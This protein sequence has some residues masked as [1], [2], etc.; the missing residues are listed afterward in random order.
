M[1]GFLNGVTENAV[2]KSEFGCPWWDDWVT[3]RKCLKIGVPTGNIGPASY[4]GAWHDFPMPNGGTFNQ[5]EHV[6]EQ[7]RWF[8]HIRTHH[9]TPWV[10]FWI[11]RGGLQKATVSP[12]HGWMFFRVINGKLSLMML[13]RSADFPVGVPAD[14]VQYGAL[15]LMMSH[16]TG[17]T[18]HE[19]VHAFFDAHIYM[20]QF[21]SVETMIHRSPKKLP[22]LILT[23]E[24]LGIE[25]I[26]DFRP[27][28]F[29]LFDYHPHPSIMKIPVSV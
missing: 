13:Q 29:N 6:V 8:P 28:H 5:I 23:D 19:F 1:C 20:N 22:T 7:L 24:G 18:P 3:E 14:M 27:K 26:F 16:V 25:N 10:P 11:G 4:G 17:Y 15:L 9:I 12:C 21:D 2:L